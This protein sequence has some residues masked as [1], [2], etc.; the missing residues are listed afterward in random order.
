MNLR[1][2]S[3]M[4][5]P[6]DKAVGDI[7]QFI[8]DELQSIRSIMATMMGKI[9]AMDGKIQTMDARIDRMDGKMGT[10]A[11]KDDLVQVESRLSH[12]MR[13]YQEANITHHLETKAMLGDI[14]QQHTPR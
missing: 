14:A 11:T 8:L 2:G 4:A 10:M 1:K 6:T 7:T 5:K 13:S 12:R 9:Q 3:T